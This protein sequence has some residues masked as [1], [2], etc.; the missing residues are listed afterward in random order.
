[1]RLRPKLALGPRLHIHWV[2]VRIGQPS[3]TVE[4]D[5]KFMSN[6]DP[7]TLFRRSGPSFTPSQTKTILSGI[8]SIVLDLRNVFLKSL[9]SLP[10]RMMSYF[11]LSVKRAL[12]NDFG[13]MLIVI[14]DRSLL[15]CG[16][17]REEVYS[18]WSVTTCESSSIE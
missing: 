15:L 13:H 2:L 7:E 11:L 4:V 18:E 3:G 10:T 17:L 14:D 9:V 12:S 5:V 8:I 6:H 1:M 16:A